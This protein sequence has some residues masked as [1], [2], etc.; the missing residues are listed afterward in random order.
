MPGF[1]CG[2]MVLDKDGVSTAA[3]VAEMAAYLHTKNLSLNQQ[4]INI[5]EMYLFCYFLF[6]FFF[7]VSNDNP[8]QIILGVYYTI[9]FTFYF[10]RTVCVDYLLH[11]RTPDMAITFPEHPMS[12]AV[13]HQLFI[14]Y[15]DVC[16]ILGVQVFTQN[17]V[18]TTAS[19]TSEI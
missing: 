15:L 8:I 14:E 1:L 4:L 19:H 12:S 6:F 9:A 5:Y 3:V 7:F 16:A 2:N 11:C 17:H 18:E 10:D 13:T